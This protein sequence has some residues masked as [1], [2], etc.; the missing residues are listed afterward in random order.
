MISV[1]SVVIQCFLCRRLCS[2]LICQIEGFNSFLN[3]CI[4]MY[5]LVA[6][7]IIRYLTTANTSSRNI[8]QLFQK[9]NLS[10]VIVCFILGSIWAVPP[11]FGRMN[12]YVPE[13]L[14]FHCGLNWFDRSLVSRIYFFLL[15]IGVYF[16]PMIIII[17]VNVYIHHTVH[18]LTHLNPIVSLEMT[19]EN[20]LRKHISVIASKKARQRLHRLYEDRRFVLATGISLIIYLIAWTLYSLVALAQVFGDSFSLYNPW[21]MTTCALITKLAMIINP[22]IYTTILKS[23]EVQ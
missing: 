15:F 3:G 18:R 8:Q 16:I 19:N 21:L 22:I 7:S 1:P 23:R 20:L 14:G 10:L 9:Y 5:M 4:T 17:Y 2:S 13:G 12:A 11:I 6:L